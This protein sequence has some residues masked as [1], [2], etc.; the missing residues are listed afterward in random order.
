MAGGE[1]RGGWKG[2]DEGGRNR[3]GVRKHNGMIGRK[4]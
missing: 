1:R 2:G 4:R 3:E